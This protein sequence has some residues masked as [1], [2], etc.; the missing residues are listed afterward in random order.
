[1]NGNT[2]SINSLSQTVSNY[3]QATATQINAI[4]ATINGNT[5]AWQVAGRLTTRF[6]G[7][8]TRDLTLESSR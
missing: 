3:Q 8:S 1:V 7:Y 5:A 4:T 2:A 6:T